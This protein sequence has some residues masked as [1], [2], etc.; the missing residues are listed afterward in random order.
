M[1]ECPLSD[2]RPLLAVVWHACMQVRWILVSSTGAVHRTKC[3]GDVNAGA[4]RLFPVLGDFGG[5]RLQAALNGELPRVLK[6][7]AKECA[8]CKHTYQQAVPV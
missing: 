1:L 2:S 7:A 3:C 5:E 6:Q 4:D 8:N